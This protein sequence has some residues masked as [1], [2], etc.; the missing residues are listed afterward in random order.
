MNQYSGTVLIVRVFSIN[1]HFIATLELNKWLVYLEACRREW[2][3][4]YLNYIA[5]MS[6]WLEG[7]YFKFICF[8]TFWI[9]L[10][11]LNSSGLAYIIIT[12]CSILS[13]VVKPVFANLI[14]FFV[15]FKSKYFN[16]LH[17]NTIS[18]TRILLYIEAKIFRHFNR[19]D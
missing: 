17:V 16:I 7:L 3:I 4:F 1:K 15:D 19:Y 11:K 8:I 10:R 6:L 2:H 13:D 12:H 18:C 9:K 14:M 5:V